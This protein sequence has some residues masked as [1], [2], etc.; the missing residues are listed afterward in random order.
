MKNIN[1]TNSNV[2]VNANL[3]VANV[4]QINSGVMIYVDVSLNYQ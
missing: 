4:I 1:K 3:M 2:I